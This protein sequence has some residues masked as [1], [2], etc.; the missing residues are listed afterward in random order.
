MTPISNLPG[1][2][3]IL[4]DLSRLLSRVTHATPT[5][6]DR[7]EMAYARGLLAT[8]PDRLAFAAVHPTG[9]YGR[10]ARSAVLRFL[11]LT[12]ERWASRG[13]D[14]IWDKRR[15]VAGALAALRPRLPDRSR[16]ARPRVYV[17]AS[18][19]NLTRPR[20]IQRILDHEHAKFVCLVHD[21]IPLEFPEY[22]RAD[23]VAKHQRRIQTIV[24]KADGIIT[25]SHATMASL[26]PWLHGS[27]RPR[28]TAVAHLGT[29]VSQVRKP[30]AAPGERPY[31]VCIGTIEPRKNHLLLLHI[32]RRLA[33]Q[34]GAD[35]VPKLVVIGR[36][37]WEN[38]Q[39][40]DML[41]RCVA[42]R[43]CVE[44]HGRLTD[45]EIAPL[46]TGARALL[47]PSFAEGYGMPV[48]EALTMGVPVLCS[49]LPA[50]REA[51]QDVPDYLDPLDGP[52]WKTAIED[53]AHDQSV[54]RRR[55]H[56]RLVGWRGPTWDQHLAILIELLHRL[57]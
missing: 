29:H 45:R 1:E 38:E 44:E 22:G 31:F 16:Q 10:L 5:G 52:G 50:L 13:F 36:R 19:N 30:L 6:V 34:H 26:Q 4:L 32:W 46:L 47:M 51:G 21:L 23:G 17:Q 48:T 24:D 12:E 2:P 53:L 35:N 40:V 57:P 56:E 20:L 49:D 37:G 9:F 14:S 54:V 11:D 7:C 41:D 8:V 15:F 28:E 27:T 33:E 55:Q 25:N 39:V 18:P 3:E 42:L 43:G